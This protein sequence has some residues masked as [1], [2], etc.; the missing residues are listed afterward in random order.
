VRLVP[1]DDGMR[2]DLWNVEVMHTLFLPRLPWRGFTEQ[3]QL[4]H[5]F[6]VWDTPPV[7]PTPFL[8]LQSAPRTSY[9]SP[10]KISGRVLSLRTVPPAFSSSRIDPCI[11]LL[12]RTLKRQY[13]LEIVSPHAVSSPFVPFMVAAFPLLPR[14][15][16][17]S[18]P[19]RTAPGGVAAFL[20]VLRLISPRCC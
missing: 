10:L 6:Y 19:P 4:G 20:L 16:A 8:R 1:T 5:F 18:T 2:R 9:R 14:F 3:A 13:G 17:G 12:R 11:A 15:R 7:F